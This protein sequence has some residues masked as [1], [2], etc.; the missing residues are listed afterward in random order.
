MLNYYT[1]FDLEKKQVGFIGSVHVEKISYW[2]DIMYLGLIMMITGSVVYLAMSF[3]AERRM[4][5]IALRVQENSSPL[6]DIRA[7]SRL[8]NNNNNQYSSIN[9]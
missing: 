5:K 6:R 8:L 9:V 3:Y 7:D 4:S 2:N 1:I